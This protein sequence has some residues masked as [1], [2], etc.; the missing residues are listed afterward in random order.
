MYL[1]ADGHDDLAWFV[2]A[3]VAGLVVHDRWDINGLLADSKLPH[4]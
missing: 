2:A 4:C 1:H 3:A